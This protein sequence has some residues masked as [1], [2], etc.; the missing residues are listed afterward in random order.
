MR[1]VNMNIYGG[2]QPTR[3]E[4]NVGEQEAAVESRM[5]VVEAGPEHEQ[6]GGSHS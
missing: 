5:G 2:A 4:I 1:D 6:G 3:K